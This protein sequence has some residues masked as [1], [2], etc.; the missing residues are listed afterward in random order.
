MDYAAIICIGQGTTEPLN[1][2]TSE[3]TINGT[4]AD[5]GSNHRLFSYQRSKHKQGSPL[6]TSSSWGK[7]SRRSQEC[8]P[9]LR[10]TRFTGGSSEPEKPTRVLPSVKPSKPRKVLPRFHY[11]H[12]PLD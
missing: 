7:S 2:D 8:K 3:E 5:Y 4:A 10:I 9:S 6:Q 11:S 12:P 1:S